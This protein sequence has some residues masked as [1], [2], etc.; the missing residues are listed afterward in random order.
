MY[1]FKR[2]TP[3]ADDWSVIENTYDNTV[4]KTAAWF[5]FLENIGC[6]PFVCEVFK[7]DKKVGFFVGELKKRIFN[8]I[9]API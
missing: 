5:D 7:Y 6:K 8:L 9:G 2:I 1:S 3:V 4:Y